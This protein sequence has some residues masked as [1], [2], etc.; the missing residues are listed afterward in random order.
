MSHSCA[1][2]D[3]TIFAGMERSASHNK[4]IFDIFGDDVELQDAFP[5]FDYAM[6]EHIDEEP[7]SDPGGHNWLTSL[8]Q[9]ESDIVLLTSN[10]VT[11]SDVPPIDASLTSNDS[12][13]SMHSISTSSRQPRLPASDR[14]LLDAWL[15]KN[16]RDPY[17]KSG[18]AEAL[19][20]LTSLKPHQVQVYMR[21]ARARRT[22]TG[23]L[24]P[25]EFPI[26][27]VLTLSL[28]GQTPLCSLLPW[29]PCPVYARTSHFLH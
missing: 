2:T 6:L 17:L 11:T 22:S 25:A 24:N 8:P 5:D 12:F 4:G 28:F 9:R 16:K 14:L 27:T 3:V 21:N 15:D 1:T 23:S 10:D 18:D 7:M 26:V 13:G 29:P 20:H 19:A